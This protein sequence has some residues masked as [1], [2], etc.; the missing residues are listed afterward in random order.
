MKKLL[1]LLAFFCLVSFLNPLSGQTTD[2]FQA[3][4]SEYADKF[5]QEK[6]HI[7]TDRDN[8]GAGETIWY[9]IYSVI[10]IENK[11]SVL[12][13]ISYVELISP[14]GEIVSQKINSLFTGVAV[15]DL[16]L[17][18]TLVEGS[19]R[20]RA[21]TNW[22]RNSSSDYYF[23]KVLNIGNVRSDNIV[24]STELISEENTEY[25]VMRF[26][27]PE[28]KD[29]EKTQVGY[30]VVEG[31]KIIDKG[32][33][34]LQPDGTVK[35][36]VNSKNKGKPI[37]LRFRNLDGSIVKKL[38][39]TNVF[40][41]DNSV[42]H[43]VEG[44]QIVGNELNRIAFKTLNPQGLGIKADIYILSSTQDTAAS[45]STN[46]LGMGSVPCYL[47]AGETYKIN[48][49]FDDGTQKT[50]DLEII[51]TNSIS[52][53]VNNSN[54]DKLLV[55][56][57]VSESMINN[58]DLYVTLQHLGNIYYMAKNRA[59]QAN[60]LFSIPRQGLPS[61]VLTVS[62]LNK[63][64]IPISERA[65]FNFNNSS[66]LPSDIKF[67]KATYGLREKVN[68]TIDVGQAGD[69][70]R[71]SALSASVVNLK[72]YKDN[73]P[74]AVSIL[75]SF[76]LN[77]DIRGFIENPSFYFNED[78]TVKSGD[79]DDLMLTQGW[80][81]I[82]ISML[83]SIA[84]LE[85]AFKAEK[86]LTIDGSIKRVGRN[87]PVPNASIQ[88]ISTNNFMEYLDTTANAEGYFSF[89][90]LL[91]PDSVKFLLSARNQKGKNFV[92]IVSNS[93]LS[94]D[95]NFEKNQPLIKNDINKLN[96]DQLAASKKFYEQLER[97]GI[98]DKVFQ[99]EEVTVRARRP[100]AAENS[101]N[102]NGPGNAD[103]TLTAE[104]LSTCATLEMCLNGRLTGVIF[105]NGI[106][107]TTRGGGAM[108]VVVDGMYMEPEILS[109]INPA[110]VE[111]VEVLR[112]ANY[113]SIY[114][115]YGASGLIIITSKTGRNARSSAYQPTGIL[116]ITPKGISLT[117]EFYKPIYEVNSETQF[118]SDLRTTIHW[119]PGIV[120]NENGHAKFDFYTSDEGGTYRMIIEGLDFNG[121]I[122]RK[123]LQFEVKE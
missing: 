34:P 50:T 112:N 46:A 33:E 36:K 74:N 92:D 32:R 78:G 35:I 19:Y 28:G 7:Q 54:S 6:I 41:T 61:G 108:Q 8:Y 95:I 15:G 79:L 47:A 24:S 119:E 104:D 29:W 59:S 82:K 10:G 45:L 113:T 106:P 83:D 14:T 87:A 11:L 17:S 105:Q 23:E 21:Y 121:R 69:S 101:S 98:M 26:K 16:V 96:E 5:P 4:M 67:D 65:V 13:N 27:N 76:F 9:K 49:K 117:K 40:N 55:Q 109:T 100:K 85:P 58:E 107:T 1:S 37:S 73:V 102:L 77:G 63:N 94:P 120:T 51:P 91:F 116:S 18:D 86:G 70:I 48:V 111:S 90:N 64:F 31:D 115:S 93:Y 122:L 57:N 39:N 110:D 20:M 123:I 103:Q 84:T 66:I 62:L 99:I 88:L 22:M 42:Q 30:Q 56:V 2:Q 80:R 114:G 44:G 12:S 75:S 43:F 53:A 60:V 52:V 71:F 81:K 38:I 25:Y 72:N 118:Q 97:K 68:T 3:K 89:D